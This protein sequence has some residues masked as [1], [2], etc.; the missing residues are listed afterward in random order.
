MFDNK[1]MYLHDEFGCVDK[2]DFNWL[3]HCPGVPI[4]VHR[5]GKFL[6][7]LI[8]HEWPSADA[9]INDYWNENNWFSGD[10]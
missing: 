6:D 9:Y 4:M 7:T 1:C 2:E 10:K 3:T 8:Y 5:H